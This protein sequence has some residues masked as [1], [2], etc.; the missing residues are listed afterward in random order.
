MLIKKIDK[1]YITLANEKIPLTA[2]YRLHKIQKNV[3]KLVSTASIV[4]FYANILTTVKVTVRNTVQFAVDPEARSDIVSG[5]VHEK[6]HQ[7]R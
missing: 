1:I 2:D 3:Y 4:A 6:L 5:T 7:F